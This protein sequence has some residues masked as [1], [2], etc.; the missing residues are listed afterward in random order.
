MNLHDENDDD[1]LRGFEVADTDG[2]VLFFGRP[3]HSIQNTLLNL[4]QTK[5]I[6]F[7]KHYCFYQHLHRAFHLNQFPVLICLL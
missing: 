7:A 6:S 5:F 1:G 4:P 2:Y 3:G